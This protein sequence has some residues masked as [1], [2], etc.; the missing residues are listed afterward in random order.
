MPRPEDEF[1]D[2]DRSRRRDEDDFDRPPPRRS[3]SKVLPILLGVGLVVVLCGACGIAGLFY[4]TTRI[5]DAANRMKSNN[6]LKQIGLGIHNYNDATNELP[7]NS[8]GADGKP[9]LSWR[10]H[11]LPYVEYDNLYKQFKLDEPWDSP[12][13]MRL[14]SQMPVVYLSPTDP[15]GSTNKTYYR[16][17]ASPGAIFE[18]R[19]NRN[20]AGAVIGGPA[21][22]FKKK[23]AFNLGALKDLPSETLLLVEAGDPVEWTKPDDLD[24][25]PG[26]PF[27]KLGGVPWK[28]NRV[29]VLMADGTTRQIR[30]D[31][32]ETTLRALVTHSGGET[33]PPGWDE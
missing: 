20:P 9:L 8:Y 23:D 21:F 2:F 18:K 24:A 28:S 25:S 27:P 6:N 32:P 4:S 11:I 1:D 12:N 13:N 15:R 17:F 3:G 5:R 30:P 16:G 29:Q 14:L 7:G 33:I 22:E 26:K 10:V 19:A 31:L